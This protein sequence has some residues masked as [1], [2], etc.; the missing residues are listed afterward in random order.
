MH[1][2]ELLDLVDALPIALGGSDQ[3]V[4]GQRQR[5]EDE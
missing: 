2:R 3:L 5:R 4:R 1:A